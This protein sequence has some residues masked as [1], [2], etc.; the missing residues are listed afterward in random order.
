MDDKAKSRK[1]FNSHSSTFVNKNGYWSH[2]YRATL[3]LLEEHGSRDHID[4]GCGNGAFLDSLH[5]E[6]P[7][8]R[9]S[10]LDYSAEMV[11]Q[12]RKRLPDAEIVE[13]DAEKMPLPDSAFD[14]VSCHMS[15]HHYPHPE[16]ALSEMFRILKDGGIVIINDLTGPG[17]LVRL[18]NRSFRYLNTGDHAIYTRNEM[19]T[20]LRRAGFCDVKS[21]NISPFS[22]VCCGSKPHGNS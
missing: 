6:A 19:E 5:K 13:G 11:R 4:I 15:I 3:D 10:G 12:S 18:M 21:R 7:A 9:L 22:Y 16:Q 1:Y 8:V 17:W 20:M 14:S 2:D